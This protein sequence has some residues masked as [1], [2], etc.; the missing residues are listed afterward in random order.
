MMALAGLAAAEPTNKAD[1]PAVGSGGIIQRID[2]DTFLKIVQEIGWSGELTETDK[3]IPVVV[4]VYKD[5]AGN[6]FAF[7]AGL[8]RC[9]EGKGCFDLVF[10]RSFEARK[11]ITLQMVNAYNQTQL[12][13]CAYLNPD[14]EVGIS[15]SHT[16][17]GG[18]TRQTVKEILDWWREVMVNAETKIAP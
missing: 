1:T 6:E 14:G 7:Q 5:E 16:I 11:P 10:T 18:V 8:Y 15:M 9:E 12:F 3:G 2:G 13:G 17:Q 4:G